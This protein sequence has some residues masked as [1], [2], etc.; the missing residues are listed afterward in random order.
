MIHL[1]RK[2]TPGSF[3]LTNV[4]VFYLHQTVLICFHIKSFTLCI[5][6]FV[7]SPYS[8]FSHDFLS[9]SPCQGLC[10]SS[11]CSEPSKLFCLQHFCYLWFSWKSLKFHVES[12][13]VNEGFTNSSAGGRIKYLI[14][15]GC[16]LSLI[17]MGCVHSMIWLQQYNMIQ[18]LHCE[19]GGVSTML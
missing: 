15:H 10:E 12:Q 4:H 2:E 19:I 18:E 11:C 14:L 13:N 9:C 8:R 3:L 7:S 6:G 1:L 17:F 16:F 5:F